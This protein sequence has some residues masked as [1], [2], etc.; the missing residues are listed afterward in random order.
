LSAVY[1]V[2]SVSCVCLNA[3][4]YVFVCMI[5]WMIRLPC[6]ITDQLAHKIAFRLFTRLILTLK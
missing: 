1:Y 6:E 5:P 2:H 3:L 4:V